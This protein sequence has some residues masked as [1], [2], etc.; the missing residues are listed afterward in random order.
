M[1]K[2]ISLFAWLI[3]ILFFGGCSDD[4][5]I[6]INDLASNNELSLN[7]KNN[8]YSFALNAIKASNLYE[9]NVVFDKESLKISSAVNSWA[10]G[11]VKLVIYSGNNVIYSKTLNGMAAVAETINGSPDKIEVTL[12]SFTGQTA[13]SVIGE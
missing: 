8:S 11:S 4:G 7:V 12:L 1:R 5:F 3:L 2:R 10:G 13:I 9:N 6:D